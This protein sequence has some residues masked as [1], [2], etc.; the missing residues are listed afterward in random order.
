MKKVVTLILAVLL[1]GS[2][3]TACGSTGSSKTKEP[4]FIELISYAETALEDIT[5][6][7]V[8]VSV[9]EEDWEIT[10]VNL[11]Y[12]LKSTVDIGGVPSDV[13]IKYEF[14]DKTYQ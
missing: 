7:D 9:K 6:K 5:K 1:I 11:R 3:S 13:I 2:I 10:N 14:E 8:S 4:T 12:V